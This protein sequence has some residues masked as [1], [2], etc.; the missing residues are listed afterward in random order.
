MDI[1]NLNDLWEKI[2]DEYKKDEKALKKRQKK[3]LKNLTKNVKA[4]K[5]KREKVKKMLDDYVYKNYDK[6][7]N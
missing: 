6:P 1:K 4:N 3:T 2:E 7:V 5:E